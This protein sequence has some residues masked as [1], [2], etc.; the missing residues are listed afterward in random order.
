MVL[1]RRQGACVNTSATA[2]TGASTMSC[3][4]QTLC[5][6]QASSRPVLRLE[7]HATFL[8]KHTNFFTILQESRESASRRGLAEFCQAH[9]H[10][11]ITFMVADFALSAFPV[12]LLPRRFVLGLRPT[13][14]MSG[15]LDRTPLGNRNRFSAMTVDDDAAIAAAAPAVDHLRS[16]PC[17]SPRSFRPVCRA[18]HRPK[19]RRFA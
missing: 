1:L 11:A 12:M 13:S 10:S 6:E 8:P 3:L 2:D 4:T 15:T 7:K 18:V 16:A 9:V 14:S 19:Y 17:A 5:V